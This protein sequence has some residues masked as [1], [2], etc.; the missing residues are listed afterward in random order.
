MIFSGWM[1]GIISSFK[2]KSLAG[3][4]GLF[5]ARN[6]LKSAKNL[7]KLNSKKPLHSFLLWKL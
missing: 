5:Q 1:N 2:G 7:D 6:L 3:K 4:V